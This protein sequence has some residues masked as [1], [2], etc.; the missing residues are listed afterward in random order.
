MSP[1]SLGSDQKTFQVVRGERFEVVL[2]FEYARYTDYMMTETNVAH[3]VHQGEPEA[4]I[5]QWCTSTLDP[6]FAGGVREVRFHAYLAQLTLP[7]TV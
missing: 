1:E 5:R 7:G 6:L 3:A 2:P 4:A